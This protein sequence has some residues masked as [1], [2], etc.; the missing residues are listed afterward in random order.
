MFEN[1]NPARLVRQY[2]SLAGKALKWE[3]VHTKIA[4]YLGI[5]NDRVAQGRTRRI[6]T[7]S[8]KRNPGERYKMELARR[9]RYV[10]KE[11]KLD[12]ARN[13]AIRE[14]KE[15]AKIGDVIRHGGQALDSRDRPPISELETSG[16]SGRWMCL[17]GWGRWGREGARK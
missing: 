10:R 13:Y 3:R 8:T 1:T 4:G 2:R 11:V 17:G 16:V 12:I 9:Y 15:V 5:A 14:V 7:Q 6:H